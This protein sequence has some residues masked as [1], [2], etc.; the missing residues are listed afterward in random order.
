LRLILSNG[1]AGVKLF[2]SMILPLAPLLP[3]RIQSFGINP[4]EISLMTMSLVLDYASWTKWGNL[5]DR[6]GYQLLMY[7]EKII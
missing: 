7:L 4:L 1:Y 5:E 3:Q 2:V 6:R